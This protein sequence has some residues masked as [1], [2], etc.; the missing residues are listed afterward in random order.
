MYVNKPL[1][2]GSLFPCKKYF[3]R[4]AKLNICFVLVHI[5]NI[6]VKYSHCRPNFFNTVSDILNKNMILPMSSF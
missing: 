2:T 1:R 3:K 5:R 4:I 6:Y